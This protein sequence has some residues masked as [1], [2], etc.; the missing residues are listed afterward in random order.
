MLKF[1]YMYPCEINIP[2]PS[3]NLN[4]SYFI[5]YNIFAFHFIVHE[6]YCN[7]V[8]ILLYIQFIFENKLNLLKTLNA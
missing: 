1:N 8:N 5:H 6:L 3:E 7:I 2:V 4:T